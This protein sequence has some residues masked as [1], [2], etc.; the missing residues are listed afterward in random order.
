MLARV[1]LERGV[2]AEALEPCGEARVILRDVG[3]EEGE[4]QLR[5]VHAEALTAAGATEAAT[6][7]ISS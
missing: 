1:L 2:V 5:L 7:A 6:T 3:V 4:E